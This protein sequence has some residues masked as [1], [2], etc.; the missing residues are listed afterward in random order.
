MLKIRRLKLGDY[1]DNSGRHCAMMSFTN[2]DEVCSFWFTHPVPPDEA[3]IAA[4]GLS[5][6]LGFPLDDQVAAQHP[7]APVSVEEK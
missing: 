6:L 4:E 3:R 2:D 1:G 5:E 7:P